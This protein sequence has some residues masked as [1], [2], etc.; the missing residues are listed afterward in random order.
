MHA[1]ECVDPWGRGYPPGLRTRG[2]GFDSHWVRFSFFQSR[3]KGS[4]DVDAVGLVGRT[5]VVARR[6]LVCTGIGRG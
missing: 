6:C 5:R 2:R 3:K 1:I 4:F